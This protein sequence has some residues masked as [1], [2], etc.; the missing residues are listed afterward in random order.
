MNDT[1]PNPPPFSKLV[2]LVGGSWSIGRINAASAK[3]F[4]SYDDAIY[5]FEAGEDNSKYY[6]KI[7]NPVSS[8]DP[9]LLRGLSLMLR[10]VIQK[11]EIPLL[12]PTSLRSNADDDLIMMECACLDGKSRKCYARLF[13]WID[14]SPLYHEK[15]QNSTIY[16]QIGVVMGNMYK[17]LDGFDHAAF[18]RKQMWDCAQF[19]L[20]M[21]TE[22]IDLIDDEDIA[23]LIRDVYAAY[24][25]DVLPIAKDL[26]QSVIMSDCNDGNIIVSSN[27]LTIKGLIDFDDA[28]YTWTVNDIA[29]S[30]AY[31]LLTNFGKENPVSL[32]SHMLLGYCQHRPLSD[33]EMKVLYT[34]IAV[35]LS[36]SIMVGAY[37]IS[38]EP[39]NP[40]LKIHAEPARNA[41]RWLRGAS[42]LTE[43]PMNAANAYSLFC[44]VQQVAMLKKSGE[45]LLNSSVSP[46]AEGVLPVISVV[47]SQALL[48]IMNK[49]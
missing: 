22:Y 19:H 49:L 31:G 29:I 41:L 37:A 38:Q 4:E 10:S 13:S 21:D 45:L 25:E 47:E 34:L 15:E 2:D 9:I 40:Y 14:G 26:P 1:K 33:V 42:T 12:V 32:I 11:L 43:Q 36:I 48:S 46:V 44:Q 8:G 28:V 39:D 3:K 6:L 7:Y 5:Y 24:N 18:H 27:P 16:Y 17:S 20:A 30:V 23:P 35:R